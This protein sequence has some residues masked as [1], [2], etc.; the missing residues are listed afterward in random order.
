M[1]GW[2]PNPTDLVNVLYTN[3]VG[4]APAAADLKYYTGLVNS[5]AYTQV[6][7][8]GLASETSLNLSSIGFDTVL[9][10]GVGYV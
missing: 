6:A 5:G 9:L 2:A 1:K 7:L 8:A 10:N 3:V 4:V